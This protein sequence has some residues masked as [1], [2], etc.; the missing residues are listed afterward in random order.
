MRHA[1]PD[2]VLGAAVV[3]VRDLWT[4]AD[5]VY[6]EVRTA[7]NW[8]ATCLLVDRGEWHV[9]HA[10]RLDRGE[11]WQQALAVAVLP[12]DRSTKAAA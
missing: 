8:V 3:E 5:R 2:D 12:H 1:P 10:Y 9:C 7:A 6:C 4:V 11:A